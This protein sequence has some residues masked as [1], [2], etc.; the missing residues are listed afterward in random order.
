[1]KPKLS[2]AS[3]ILSTTQTDP[4]PLGRF[5]LIAS[6]KGLTHLI[7][8]PDIAGILQELEEK[9]VVISPEENPLLTQTKTEI[10]DY[11]TGKLKKFTIPVDL[12][13]FS[14]FYVEV[15]MATQA[16]PYG[17]TQS[18]A[19]IAR[20]IGKPQ[21]ARAVGQVEAKNPIPIIIPCHR[22]IGSDGRLHGYGGPG[23]LQTK[24]WLLKLEGNP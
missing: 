13:G 23:G 20:Q 3:Q 8:Q 1:M 19:D 16:I 2:F 6:E 17:S 18:Y 4:T 21:A 22:V 14:P 7:F 5:L 11:F 10:L 9:K 12:Q 15:L 24:A